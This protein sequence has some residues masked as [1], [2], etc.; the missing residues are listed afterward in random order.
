MNGRVFWND[1]EKRQIA[2]T[3]YKL[4]E[5]NPDLSILSAVAQAQRVTLP[6]DRRRDIDT[7]TKVTPWLTPL[8]DEMKRGVQTDAL[9]HAEALFDVKQDYDGVNIDTPRVEALKPPGE[10]ADTQSPAVEPPTEQTPV[11]TPAEPEQKQSS[12]TAVHWNDDERKIVATKARE[13]LKRWPD[14]TKLEAFR[15][16][17]EVALLP[18]RQRSLITWGNL[19][20]W[21][22]PMLS[23][24]ELD[25]QIAEARQRE[26]REQH[27][28]QIRAEVEDAERQAE[29][30]IAAQRMRL[31]AFEQEVQQRVELM[32]FDALIRAFAAKIARETVNAMGEEFERLLMGRVLDAAGIIRNR[33][34]TTPDATNHYVVPPASRLPRVTVVGLMRQQAD[35]V[36]KAYLG[37]IDFTFIESSKTGGKQGGGAGLAAHASTTDVAIAMVDFAGHDVD[38]AAKRLKLPFVRINGN[39]SAL[40]RWLSSWLNGEIALKCV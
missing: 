6:T 24:L 30:A 12:R 4:R 28:A 26:E 20:A 33:T 7:V 40:K 25:E 17:Q 2:A 15:K 1:G 39:V 11:S 19:E 37:A 34:E 5:A 35:D 21:A 18:E 3:A 31:E 29:A 8:W 14:M 13:I 23:V 27:D 10:V 22:D 9:A 16:A 32:P 36:K 38:E